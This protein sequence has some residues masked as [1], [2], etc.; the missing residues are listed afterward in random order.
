MSVNAI[1]F[2][3]AAEWNCILYWK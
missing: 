3:R 2:A 1:T